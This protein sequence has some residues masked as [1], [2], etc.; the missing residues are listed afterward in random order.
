MQQ[1]FKNLQSSQAYFSDVAGFMCL[2]IRKDISKNNY[3]TK[4]K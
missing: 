2:V 4:Y 1:T 3:N